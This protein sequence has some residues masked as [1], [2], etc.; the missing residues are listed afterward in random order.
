MPLD[1]NEDDLKKYFPTAFGKQ[2]TAQNLERKFNETKRSV[3]VVKKQNNKNKVDSE[4]YEI[5]SE[6]LPKPGFSSSEDEDDDL[7]ITHELALLSHT[8]AVSTLTLDPSG[9]RLLSGGHDFCM[10]FWDFA[11]MSSSARAFRSLDP[12]PNHRLH[13]IQYSVS[14]DS[15]LIIGGNSQP[16]IVD[17]E[18]TE[19]AEYI[20]GDMYLRDLRNTDGHVAETT[21]GAWNPID[22]QTFI[23]SSVDSTI[24]IWDVN[25]KSKN[26]SVIFL[27]SKQKGQKTEVTTCAYS[28]DGNTIA[29]AG[30]D[31]TLNL[32]NANGPFHRPTFGVVNGHT[33]G[34][35]TSSVLFSR[36]GRMLV[37]R[38]GDDTVKLWDT[39]NF[40]KAV[41]SKE[42][43]DNAFSE[44]NI[45]YSPDQQYLCS[46]ISVSPESDGTG[47]LMVL[48]AMTLE[49]VQQVPIEKASVISCLWHG[50]LNQIIIGSSNGK[51]TVL[52][53]PELSTN[54][55]KLALSKTRK[56]R[57][58]DDDA[59]LTTDI[60]GS[61]LVNVL[62][63]GNP[64]PTD[65]TQV[66]SR[67]LA[68]MNR[69]DPIKSKKPDL[70]FG[71]LWG[72][73]GLY[74]KK[75]EPEKISENLESM[76][77]EDPRVALLKY[78]ELSKN[79]PM[80]TRGIYQRESTANCA[81]YQKTQ[82][83]PVFGEFEEEEE[84][85]DKKLK[86]YQ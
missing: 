75:R 29:A 71:G 48:D 63:S 50:K 11:G 22:R 49:T 40:T 53:S 79:D 20:R 45:V 26:S 70:P 57:F 66:S 21:H 30:K 28:P 64:D 23:T 32:W 35:H 47:S 85:Q 1:G 10:K 15:V 68:N 52:Y 14:G 56:K 74:G 3:N 7:P 55:A 69:K 38:G 8:R 27:S 51:I 24:R 80:F 31:G 62:P 81:A 72:T 5:N 83:V 41:R 65:S 33:A 67:R 76:R 9:S 36:D 6:S 12:I 42:G 77:D 34:S 4:D 43:L 59:S 44:T 58:I 61:T 2:T 19:L 17:R 25:R 54:G 82:P 60:D 73:G 39:R 16:K 13:H 37:S 46:G 86:R 18:G 84:H 78:D